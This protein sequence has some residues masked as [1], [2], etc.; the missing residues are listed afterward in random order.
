LVTDQSIAGKLKKLRIRKAEDNFAVVIYSLSF[1]HRFYINI[2]MK[3]D[4]TEPRLPVDRLRHPL[5]PIENE[6]E[7]PEDLLFGNN[8][9]EELEKVVRRLYKQKIKNR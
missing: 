3:I 1:F 8:Q 6:P 9:G 5:K 7:Q 2:S 4:T